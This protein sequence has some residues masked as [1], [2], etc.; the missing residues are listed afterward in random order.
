ME[1]VQGETMKKTVLLVEDDDFINDIYNVKLSYE[2]INVVV[3]MNGA[4]AIN[5]LE[6]GVKPN[7]ILLDLVM[8]VMDGMG[9]LR[10]LKSTEA[11]KD[12]PV[13]LLTNLSDK[14]QIEE[15]L[16]LGANDYIVKSHFTPTEVMAKVEA[17]MS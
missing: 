3:A 9:V 10:R 15:C 2:G 5:H 12:I 11:W 6:N 13:V 1:N 4:E 8:P 16:N 7:L 14:G 17:L